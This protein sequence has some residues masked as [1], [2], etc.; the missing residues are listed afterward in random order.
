MDRS[1]DGG[2]AETDSL[3]RVKV[4]G[5]GGEGRSP[6]SPGEHRDG[7]GAAIKHSSVVVLTGL[8]LCSGPGGRGP[9]GLISGPNGSQIEPFLARVVGIQAWLT[10]RLKELLFSVGGLFLG[11]RRHEHQSVQPSPARHDSP[12]VQFGI[13]LVGI[14]AAG[15]VL[16]RHQIRI[17]AQLRP[18]R[19]WRVQR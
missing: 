15:D 12:N 4:L 18:Q 19:R 5:W 13:T 1:H 17:R 14:S 6:R 9:L 7:Q 2:A 16:F 11:V 3:G 10:L 8:G